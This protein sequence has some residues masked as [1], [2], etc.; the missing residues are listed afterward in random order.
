MGVDWYCVI[1]I[2]SDRTEDLDTISNNIKTK[3]KRGPYDSLYRINKHKLE[4]S[5][6][7]PRGDRMEKGSLF[8]S[9]IAWTW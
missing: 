6:S 8:G 3:Y 1:E 4:Y 2:F 7:Q 9:Y 5:F